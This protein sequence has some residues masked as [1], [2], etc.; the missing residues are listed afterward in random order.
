MMRSN[1]MAGAATTV[2]SNLGN[3]PFGNIPFGIAFDGARIWT[4]N[5]S[6]SVSIVT[7]G[8]TI[9]WTVTTVTTGFSEPGGA[10]YDG[11]SVSVTDITAGTLLKVDSAGA[12]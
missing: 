7:P 4:A 11:A 3:I 5:A 10:L 9:P 12:I 6:G 8:A 2:A 1:Q